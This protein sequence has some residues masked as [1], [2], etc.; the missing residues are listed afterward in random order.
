ML[1][2][3]VLQLLL[4]TL[5]TVDNLGSVAP[6]VISIICIAAPAVSFVVNIVNAFKWMRR[7]LSVLYART[8]ALG[9]FVCEWAQ[10]AVIHLSMLTLIPRSLCTKGGD[11]LPEDSTLPASLEI[12]PY[13]GRYTDEG[14]YPAFPFPT[15]GAY[16][17]PILPI[18]ELMAYFK[19]LAR[20][21][22]SLYCQVLRTLE[23]SYI[24]P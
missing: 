24:C 4:V 6:L 10:L 5:S 14:C 8:K 15:K 13:F 2:F 3:L 19:L 17:L 9:T 21:L 12:S 16:H 7:M 11:L 22:Y 20:L 23:T 1:L 18:Y